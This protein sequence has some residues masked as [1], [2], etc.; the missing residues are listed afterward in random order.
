MSPTNADT[1]GARLRDA[2]E[3]LQLSQREAAHRA[4][5]HQ[6]DWAAI[7]TGRKPATLDHIHRLASAIGADPADVDPRLNSTARTLTL[8]ISQ[9]GVL[10]PETP[11]DHDLLCELLPVPITV[12]AG[13]R[14]SDADR[15]IQSV[16]DHR[17]K[18]VVRA[19]LPPLE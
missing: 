14:R 11:D 6:P 9:R 15:L 2:R 19:D 1:P 5:V 13:V 10:L 4:G 12:R 16:A 17:V 18:L 8:V 3:R 7:E